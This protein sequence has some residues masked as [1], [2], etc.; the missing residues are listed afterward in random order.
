[1]IWND[2]LRVESP[3][4]DLTKTPP[5]RRGLWAPPRPTLRSA[6]VP[7]PSCGPCARRSE[8][9]RNPHQYLPLIRHETLS[10]F[11]VPRA[12]RIRD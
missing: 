3:R 2:R 7:P 4:V 12:R 5:S 9:T 11:H 1:M 6:R 8:E 10:G